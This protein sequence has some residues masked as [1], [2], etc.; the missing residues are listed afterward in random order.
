MHIP[1]LPNM[2]ISWNS[3]TETNKLQ[4]T[5][6]QALSHLALRRKEEAQA[7]RSNPYLRNKQNLNE[8]L[9][10]SSNVANG[11]SDSGT[12]PLICQLPATNFWFINLGE[13][14]F[15]LQENVTS[16]CTMSFSQRSLPFLAT[17]TYWPKLGN[18]EAL[19]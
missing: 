8:N 14:T 18:Q 19:F 10:P 2:M 5:R 3:V 15:K 9:T 6:I 17:S 7:R 11:N 12:S 1:T 13:I 4:L 16:L